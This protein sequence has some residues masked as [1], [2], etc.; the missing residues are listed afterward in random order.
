MKKAFL[1][2]IIISCVLFTSVI[3]L[4]AQKV[5]PQ[6]V[7]LQQSIAKGWNTWSYESMLSHVL[8]PEGLM[9][10]LNFRQ[11]FIGTPRDPLLVINRVN[12]DTSG[13]I[14]PIAHTFDGAYTELIINNWKGNTIRVQSTAVGN[15]LAIL[16]T[17]I[18]K[19]E[20]IRFQVEVEAGI[21][22]NGKGNVKR[23]GNHM[24]AQIGNNA[25]TIQGTKENIEAYHPYTTPYLVYKGDAA[26]GIYTGKPQTLQDIKNRIQ[27]A[28]NDFH[29]YAQKYGDLAESFEAIQSVLGWNT[30]Y[31][32]AHQRVLTPVSRGWNEAWQGYV[33]FAWDTYLGAYLFALDNKELA[34]SNAI[35]VTKYPNAN[36]NIGHYQMGDGTVALMSQP[37]IGALICWQIYQKYPEKWFLE[38]V[39]NELLTWNRWWIKNRMNQGYLTWGGWKGADAQI[40]AWESGLDN[41]PMYE[42]VEMVEQENAALMNLAD[43][44]LN[45]LYTADCQS[46]AKIAEALGKSDIAKELN[47]RAEQFAK[48]TNQLWSEK[49]GFY[50]NKN[51]ST[52]TFSNRLS[53][54]LFYPMIA[55]IPN[56]NQAD[57]MLKQ[58]F[59]NKNEFYSEFM[60]PSCAFN[61]PSYDNIYWRGAIWPPLNFLAYQGIKNYSAEA[62]GELADKSH[63]LF[64]KAWKEHHYVFENI[65]SAKGVASPEDQLMADRYYHWGALMGILKFVEN[66]WYNAKK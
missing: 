48:I 65:N 6:Y 55:K 19:S 44:G 4:T 18:I 40:A 66:G 45:S 26:I 41:A 46:L 16:I 57:V 56:K 49:N 27:K 39:F 12:P 1:Q 15:D 25:F 3:T 53:P 36:G 2:K 21:L 13:L 61:D 8:L 42:G 32:A 58:H 23:D 31:D 52:D 17:P 11:A 5:S 51:L 47:Q 20:N 60:L 29:Q 33:L 54:T 50:L 35:A 28:E 24:I 43:V 34:F 64:I 14:Q 9:V 62:A 63:N 22:W 30:L 10:R 59:Y 37:P 7:K 38:E